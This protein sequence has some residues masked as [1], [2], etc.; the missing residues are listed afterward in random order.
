MKYRNLENIQHPQPRF[1]WSETSSVQTYCDLFFGKPPP[2][3]LKWFFW[4]SSTEDQ[5]PWEQRRKLTKGQG[6]HRISERSASSPLIFP[7]KR[8]RVMREG[9]KEQTRGREIRRWGKHRERLKPDLAVYLSSEKI[10]SL[11]SVHFPS[12]LMSVFIGVSY[13][14]ACW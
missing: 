11:I 8:R 4:R 10:T 13:S 5:G 9:R 6:R 12:G 1:T 3:T 2:T 14:F 7:T